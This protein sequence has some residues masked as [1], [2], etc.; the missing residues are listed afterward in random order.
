MSYEPKPIELTNV[1]IPLELNSLAQRLGENAHDVW[2]VER[3]AEGW[4]YGPDRDDVK[5]E[6]PDLVRSADLSGP[7]REYARKAAIA[8]IKTV[9]ALGYRIERAEPD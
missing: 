3:M 6:H 9:V 1:R 8:T 7:E 2:A 5:K 4:T